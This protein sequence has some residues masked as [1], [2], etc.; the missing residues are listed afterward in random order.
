FPISGLTGQLVFKSYSNHYADFNPFTRTDATDRDQSWLAPN[1]SLI[2]LHVLY[3]LPITLGPV[4]LQVFAHVFNLLDTVYIQDAV[5]NSQ[6]NAYT[7]DGKNH[8]AD[9]AEVFFGL[10]RYFNAG[11]TVNF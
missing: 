8:A 4:K 6:Y 10:P 7:G 1:Y 5:D 2:D 9:D 3:N 11:L